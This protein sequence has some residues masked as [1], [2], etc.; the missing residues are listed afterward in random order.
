M[1]RDKIN[2]AIVDDDESYT[3][4]LERRFRVSGFDVRTYLSA[5]SFLAPTTLNNATVSG[6]KGLRG[7]AGRNGRSASKR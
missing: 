1:N 6:S 7:W 2:V 3:L 5:E 4:A